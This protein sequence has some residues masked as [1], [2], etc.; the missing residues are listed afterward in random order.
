MVTEKQR[1]HIGGFYY[2]CMQLFYCMVV[3]REL[4]PDESKISM[5]NYLAV[6]FSTHARNLWEFFYGSDREPE[7]YPRVRHYVSDWSIVSNIEVKKYNGI[8][9]RQL[10]H[11][12]Y[13][14][15]ETNEPPPVAFIYPAYRHFRTL[16]IEFLDKL[17]QEIL[18]PNMKEL[19]DLMKEDLS[20][21]P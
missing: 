6:A 3:V 13:K 21:Y 10:S 12:D 11:L 18:S 17:P 14:R 16:I 15:G 20:R 7:K 19:R 9:N 4:N 5:P 2:E 1:K 8:L